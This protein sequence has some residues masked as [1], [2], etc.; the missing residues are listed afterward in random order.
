VVAAIAAVAT[1]AKV[2]AVQSRA[3]LHRR[4]QAP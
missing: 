1:A 2:S 3:Q 4:R